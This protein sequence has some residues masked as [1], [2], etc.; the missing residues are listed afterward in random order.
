[1]TDFETTLRSALQDES[2][3]L[4]AHP[5][6]A[7]DMIVNGRRIRRRRRVAGGVAGVAV[8][9][10]LVPAGTALM[11]SDGPVQ[12][13]GP[14]P[15]VTTPTT[16]KATHTT[17]TSPCCVTR[18]PPWRS[19][20]VAGHGQGHQQVQVL[21]IRVGEHGSYDRVVIDLDAPVNG[22]RIEQVPTLTK[23]GSGQ[24]VD[25]PGAVS[26][27]V[28][29]TDAV[30]H[31]SGGHSTYGGPETADYG[32]ASLRGLAF[33]GDFEGTVSFG[34]G[35]AHPTQIRVLTLSDPSRLVIDLAH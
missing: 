24:V 34:L 20:P 22:Y 9:A 19:L 5:T 2:A 14:G 32:M 4:M 26:I 11:R 30:A 35:V 27:A 25:L 18:L 21:N 6:L 10:A 23:D 29:L 13:V 17:P 16:G 7:E 1:M 3:G 28:R 12:P 8:L 31:D 15:T 33:L